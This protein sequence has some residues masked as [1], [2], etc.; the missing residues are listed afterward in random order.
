[1]PRQTAVLCILFLCGCDDAASTVAE[2]EL[3]LPRGKIEFSQGSLD[4][5]P[6]I[7]FGS[8]RYEGKRA[9]VWSDGYEGHPI[10]SDAAVKGHIHSLRPGAIECSYE[11]PVQGSRAATIDGKMY[12]IA[13]GNL[14]L[15]SLGESSIRVRQLDRDLSTV[16]LKH[17]GDNGSALKLAMRNDSEFNDFFRDRVRETNVIE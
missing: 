8:I 4:G 14:F 16:E 17:N 1:M 6:G 15:V 3:N 2:H 7:D 11:I 10:Y 12:D 9:I 13:D 5:Q